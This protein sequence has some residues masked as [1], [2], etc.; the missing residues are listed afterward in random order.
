MR[1]S[2]CPS[3]KLGKTSERGVDDTRKRFSR[4]TV[5]VG[6]GHA[7]RALG[8]EEANQPAPKRRFRNKSRGAPS[9]RAL[10][11]CF[12][13]FCNS[14]FLLIYGTLTTLIYSK[15]YPFLSTVACKYVYRCRCTFK[16]LGDRIGKR[17]TA[18]VLRFLCVLKW[19][20]K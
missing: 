19:K 11:P 1:Y 17:G 8:S 15:H 5:R 4:R 3:S 2:A 9:A 6:P 14:S 10:R 18:T 7:S 13:A 16:C 12:T 20:S